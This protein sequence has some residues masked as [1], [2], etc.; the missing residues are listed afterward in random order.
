MALNGAGL[1]GIDYERNGHKRRPPPRPVLARIESVG[2]GC[3][4]DKRLGF[5]IQPTVRPAVCVTGRG[6]VDRA[7]GIVVAVSARDQRFLSVATGL[8]ATTSSAAFKAPGRL[9]PR[10]SARRR[11]PRQAVALKK[12]RCGTAPVSKISDNEDATAALGHAE[13]LSVKDSPGDSVMGTGSRGDDPG[14]LPSVGGS[15]D[16]PSGGG[17]EEGGE[18]VAI[19]TGGRVIRE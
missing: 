19:R 5:E 12:N 14:V 11:I 17:G 15:I 4:G 16:I 2:P 13:V 8:P 18:I 9:R 6:H 10:F 1:G 7:G 3:M